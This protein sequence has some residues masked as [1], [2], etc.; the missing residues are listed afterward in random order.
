V[1]GSLCTQSRGDAVGPYARKCF[2]PSAKFLQLDGYERCLVLE[3]GSLRQSVVV[4]L[5]QTQKPLLYFHFIYCFLESEVSR[6]P[7]WK[8]LFFCLP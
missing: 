2:R 1:K 4:T 8:R 6:R 3:V 5:M 7:N